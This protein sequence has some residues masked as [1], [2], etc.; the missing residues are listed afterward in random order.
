VDVYLQAKVVF[1]AEEKT[2]ISPEEAYVTT[3]R[4]PIPVN[5]RAGKMLCTFGQHNLYH[6]HH[7]AFSE[8]PVIHEQVFGPDLNEVGVEASYLMP[9]PWY[10]DLTVGCFNGDNANLFG[11]TRQGD[12]AALVHYDNLWDLSDHSALRLGASYL[13]GRKACGDGLQTAFRSGLSRT[14]GIDFHWKWRPLRYGRYRCGVIQG[15]YVRSTIRENG[16]TT[17]PLHGFFVQALRQ[18]RLRWWVQARYDRVERP[19]VFDQWFGAEAGFP[20][21]SGDPILIRRWSFAMAFVPT[22]F[23]AFR[24]QFNWIDAGGRREN[25]VVFQMN[26]TIGSHPAH[27]Y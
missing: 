20:S 21:G 10:S 23:S 18:F 11:S 19:A 26:V 5:V 24:L 14:W 9:F 17:R 27:K 8:P 13:S 16:R 4:M 15:E 25:Q 6:L 22:E 3:L 1:A 12:Y 2:G 7:M